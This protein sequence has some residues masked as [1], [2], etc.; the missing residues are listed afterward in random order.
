M[1]KKIQNVVKLITSILILALVVFGGFFFWNWLNKS[2]APNIVTVGSVLQAIQQEPKFTATTYIIDVALRGEKKDGYVP[3]PVPLLTWVDKGVV[4]FNTKIQV[5]YKLASIKDS[6]VNIS[7][8]KIVIK[9]PSPVFCDERPSM[10]IVTIYSEGGTL[11]YK[12]IE[13]YL[14]DLAKSYALVFA[15]KRGIFEDALK[16]DLTSFENTLSLLSGK[17]VELI[18]D[19]SELDKYK[20][21][22]EEELGNKLNEKA[23]IGV[24]LMTT[25]DSMKYFDELKSRF[26]PKEI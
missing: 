14:G 10:D 25:T 8:D 3:I 1:I 5:C 23:N 17:D 4:I 20:L 13:N 9:F 18:V 6:D 16:Y 2:S 11:Q 12:E 24:N 22:K 15:I 26:A 21:S 19:E 7:D